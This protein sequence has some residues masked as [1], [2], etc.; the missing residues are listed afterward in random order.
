MPTDKIY[1]V[2]LNYNGW[3]D[4]IRC[5]SSLLALEYEYFKIIVVDN[6]SSDFSMK[7]M[8]SWASGQL[9]PINDRYDFVS[10]DNDQC[11]SI[12]YVFYESEDVAL[13]TSNLNHAIGA[14]DSKLTFIQSKNNNGFAAGNNIGIQYA[15]QQPDCD[16][17]WCLNNDLVVDKISLQNLVYCYSALYIE[18]TRIGFLGAKVMDYYK[19]THIQSVGHINNRFGRRSSVNQES[20]QG[21]N[22]IEVD[23][24]SGSSIFFSP[25]LIDEIGLIPEEYFLYYEETDWMHSARKKGFKNYTCLSA[26]VLHKEAAST[27]GV[28]SPFVVYYITRNRY[29]YN[30][31][32]LSSLSWPFY[33]TFLTAFLLLKVGLYSFTNRALSRAV[34]RA[35]I[36]GSKGRTGK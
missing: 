31:K 6:N 17:I 30:R 5:L 8:I 14:G 11:V 2:L 29:L 26:E 9:S 21:K 12:D 25:S 10:K 19:P 28:L 16:F 33:W 20:L 3:D 36:D 22:H 23:D 18:N 34:L 24:F 4:T 15:K 1:I 13:K 27:G 32:Y 35:V 7:R